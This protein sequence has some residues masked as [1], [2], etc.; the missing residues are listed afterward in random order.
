MRSGVRSGRVP[1][2]GEVALGVAGGVLRCCVVVV[3][4]GGCA[5]L[6]L[7]AWLG[8]QVGREDCDESSYVVGPAVML[9]EI[10]ALGPVP[11]TGSTGKPRGVRSQGQR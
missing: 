6:G 1:T 10:V 2:L 3:P 9:E 5:R 8:S 11:R 4:V 7:S